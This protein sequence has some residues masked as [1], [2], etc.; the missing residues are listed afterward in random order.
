MGFRNWFYKK[1]GFNLKTLKYTPQLDL[2]R[3]ESLGDNCEFGLFLQKSKNNK[4]S[5]FRFVRILDYSKVNE[6][7]ENNFSDIFL[8]ENLIPTTEEMVFDKKYKMSFHTTL[9]SHQE[10]EI[11]EF[12]YSGE[13]LLNAYN[14]ELEKI[15]YLSRKFLHD[16]KTANKI[17]VLKTNEFTSIYEINLLSQTLLSK[18]NCK[19]LNV[20]ATNESKKLFT[21]EKLNK[22]L[23][24]GYIDEFADYNSAHEFRFYSW[25]RLMNNA[26]KIIAND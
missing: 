3:F 18:G 1:T 8:F 9:R 24:I 10:K 2:S 17:Y 20:R 7:I 15:K 14:T 22:N 6:L 5:F 21:I 26:K 19:I 25:H 23:F 4:S 13:Q 16:L 12:N 11:F